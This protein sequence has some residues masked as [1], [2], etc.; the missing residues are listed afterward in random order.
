MKR[1]LIIFCL[2]GFST[3]CFSQSTIVDSV[4]FRGSLR[5]YRLYIPSAYQPHA[6]LPLVFNFHGLGS[7]ALQQEVY[8]Q[9]STVAEPAGA[10]VCY[11]N[12]IS[13][14]W[15]ITGS[16]SPDIAFVDTLIT[17]LH[18]AYSINLNRVYATGLSNGGFLSNLLACSLAHR[19]AAIAPVAGT[20]IDA[21]QQNCSSGRMMPILYIH[22][23]ADGVVAYN[24]I[25]GYAS[26]E[27]LM[28]L[29]SARAS[30]PGLTDTTLI[31]DYSL[32]DLS[33]VEK[34]TWLDCD[35]NIQ[36]IHYKIL[37][38]GHTWPGA[39]IA[40]GVTNQD[41]NASQVIMDFFSQFTLNPA[42]DEIDDR[43]IVT[44]FP[45]PFSDNL[46]IQLPTSQHSSVSVFNCE[47]RLV[48]NNSYSDEKIT[49]HPE[50]PD[51]LYLISISQGG[52]YFSS[53]IVK[54]N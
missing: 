30:C 40:I 24:G 6:S 38:G 41:I 46:E 11:P 32:T 16:N 43:L 35:S 18:D 36:V 37:G 48:F 53:R 54:I 26:T 21:V 42:V 13:N 27:E 1:I 45:N 31:P 44:L 52:Q 5:N 28:G 7:N 33:T 22:G 19:I 23:D 9:F 29:W 3:S 25:P 10:F 2:L 14:G 17:L 15:N 4:E 39:P 47:G 50:M 34:I 51:G 20:N 12:G 49:L 8:S